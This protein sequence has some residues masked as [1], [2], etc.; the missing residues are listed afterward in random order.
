MRQPPAVCGLSASRAGHVPK[1]RGLR[2][3]VFPLCS[4][5]ARYHAPLDCRSCRRCLVVATS[6]D[7]AR[8]NGRVCNSS[9]SLTLVRCRESQLLPVFVAAQG[10]DP[11]ADRRAEMASLGR[12][13]AGGLQDMIKSATAENRPGPDWMLNKAIVDYINRSPN[14]WAF[15]SHCVSPASPCVPSL[16]SP[17][18][19]RGRPPPSARRRGSDK[20]FKYLKARFVQSHVKV[21]NLSLLVRPLTTSRDRIAVIASNSIEI[22][23]GAR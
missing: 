22:G 7:P 3:T 16:P 19:L 13:K 4:F 23:D 20:A 18:T 9:T 1:G 8:V 12:G 10:R 2:A 17:R 5:R 11:L 15:P 14:R 21:Q 6:A